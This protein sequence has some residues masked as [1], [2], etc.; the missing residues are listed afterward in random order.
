MTPSKCLLI[1]LD[2]LGDRQYPELGGQTP[3]QAACTPNLDH[4]ADLGGNGLFH[5]GN[6]GE[7]FP[8]E[9]A[10]FALFG[11]PQSMFPGRG[12]LEALGAGIDLRRN[13]VV[14]LAHFVSAEN[15]YGNLY[16]VQDKPKQVQEEELQSIFSLVGG[17][18]HQG[19]CMSLHQVKDLFGVLLLEGDVSALLTDSNPMR[20]QAWATDV[21]PLQ[22]A[23][24]DDQ[25]WA[26]AR[27]VQA[28]LSFAF[29]ALDQ[30]ELN[31]R[32]RQRG[33]EPVN[34]LVTQRPG[35]ICPVPDF[36]ARTG[37]KGASIASGAMFQ[38][39]ARCIGL[40]ARDIAPE[41]NPQVDLA[42]RLDLA[43]SL[44]SECDFIHVHT[45]APDQ[46]G[47]SKNCQVK[48]KVIED[49]DR[50]LTPYMTLLAQD[51]EILTVIA[52][53]HSTPSSG[54][55]IHSGEPVPVIMRG[56]SIRRDRV[57][58]F[59]EISAACGGLSLMRDTELHRMM[60]NGL[61]KAKLHGIQE[62][63]SERLFWPGPAPGLSLE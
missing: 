49:L 9:N 25:A 36:E 3:L 21:L 39:L 10:H 60:L 26:T 2:G 24:Q 23:Q 1:V 51:P 38:G 29:H 27:A 16:I 56:R 19:V 61:N 37:L 58:A 31:T 43:V 34:A 6:L 44:L 20:D 5:A 41:D 14:L 52:S 62:V 12:A 15:R 57:Q 11:Y 63:A 13:Q 47:H 45:K 30:S 50:A 33:L 46:A 59:D 55:L 48:L 53:D 4:L 54:P 35:R 7:P 8:S 40:Q 32:R 18:E 17:F 28:Y 42:V 22:E